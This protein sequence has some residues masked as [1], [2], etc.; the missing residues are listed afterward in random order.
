MKSFFDYIKGCF[1]LLH[2]G[3]IILEK[4]IPTLFG[5][6]T[7]YAQLVKRENGRKMIVLKFGQGDFAADVWLDK[8]GANKLLE[9]L[10]DQNID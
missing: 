1:R 8:K 2:K 10:N 6:I 9:F 3:E 5:R 4:P 7:M